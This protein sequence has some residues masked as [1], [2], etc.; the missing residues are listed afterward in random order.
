MIQ[1]RIKHGQVVLDEPIPTAWEGRIVKLVP[2]TPDE[3]LAN[4]DELIAA[5]HAMGQMELDPNEREEIASALAEV[6][7]FS[8]EAL[9][10]LP[11]R[12]P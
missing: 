12:R 9:N 2:M 7:T 10:R 6:D 11:A 5:L 4:L 1:A 8:K 3:P